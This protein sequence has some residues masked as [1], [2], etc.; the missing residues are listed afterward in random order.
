VQVLKAGEHA[1]L[2][3]LERLAVARLLLPPPAEK[4]LAARP[5]AGLAP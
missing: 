3:A 5:A 4:A 1:D 2:T